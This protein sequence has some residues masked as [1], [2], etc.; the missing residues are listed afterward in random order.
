MKRRRD[1]LGTLTVGHIRPFP[2]FICNT[3]SQFINMRTVNLL[4]YKKTYHILKN[5]NQDPSVGSKL[6]QRFGVYM[7]QY[8]SPTV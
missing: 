8:L 5:S 2:D 4:A 3:H 1:H 6:S 7:K